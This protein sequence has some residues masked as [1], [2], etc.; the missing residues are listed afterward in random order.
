[1]RNVLN[2]S[3]LFFQVHGGLSHEDVFHLSRKS[4][5]NMEYLG[6][7]WLYIEKHRLPGY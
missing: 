5:Q 1:M 4:A 3:T 6:E 2:N 7:A